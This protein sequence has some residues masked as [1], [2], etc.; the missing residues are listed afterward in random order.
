M[1]TYKEKYTLDFST[2]T[3]WREIHQIIKKELDFPDYYGENWDALWDCLTEMVDEDEPLNIEI[4]GAEVLE[5]KFPEDL[6]M[7][8]EIFKE[9]KHWE[10]DYF[11]NC[12]K[13]EIVLG[14]ARYEIS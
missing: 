9:L 4:L 12:V 3:H 11:C 14:E 1:Y 2:I 13:V 6:K 8:V 5:Q 10:D 7:L